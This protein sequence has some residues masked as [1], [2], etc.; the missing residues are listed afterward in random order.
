MVQPRQ[1][2]LLA[3]AAHVTCDSCESQSPVPRNVEW[4]PLPITRQDIHMHHVKRIALGCLAAALFVATAS[5]QA[6]PGQKASEANHFIET[7]AGSNLEYT[8]RK[9]GEVGALLRAHPE[10]LYTYTTLGGTQT[11]AVDEG[12]IFV[13]MTPK[14]RSI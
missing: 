10:V 7:P 12:L 5:G 11:G 3:L 2:P 13:K 6:S 1:V 4:G 14:N 9:A 8:R